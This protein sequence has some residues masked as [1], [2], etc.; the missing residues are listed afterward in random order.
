MKQLL[1]IFIFLIGTGVSTDYF[2]QTGGKKHERR[3]K[4]RGNFVLTQYKSR[5]H[6]DKFARGNSGRKGRLAKLF[7]GKKKH[8]TWVYRSSGSKRSAYKAN[9]YLLTRSRSAGKIENAE[10]LD[11]Q[12]S[13]RSKSRV[14]G[15]TAFRSRKYK[16]R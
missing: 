2:A 6:A 16:N 3:G 14:H 7:K 10:Y 5:G 11:H 8:S 12:N 13:T 9:Q 4:R 1:F 15:N